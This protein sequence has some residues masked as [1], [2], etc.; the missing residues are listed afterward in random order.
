MIKM[1]LS[2]DYFKKL[3]TVQNLS[4]IHLYSKI[5]KKSYNKKRVLPYKS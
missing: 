5:S 1:D 3:R 4:I 2:I